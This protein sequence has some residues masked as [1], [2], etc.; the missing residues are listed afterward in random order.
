MQAASAHTQITAEHAA[1]FVSSLV[2]A[3]QLLGVW[4]EP[5]VEVVVT[6]TPSKVILQV[7]WKQAGRKCFSQKLMEG[8]LSKLL[9]GR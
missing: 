3:L 8:A 7:R 9:K 5:L 4:V 6:S 2:D 1:A